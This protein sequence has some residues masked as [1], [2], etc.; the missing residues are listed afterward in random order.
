MVSSAKML[1]KTG[2]PSV[3]HPLPGPPVSGLQLGEE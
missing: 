2:T 1:V 3:G